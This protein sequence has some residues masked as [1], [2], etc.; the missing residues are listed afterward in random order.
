LPGEPFY[1]WVMATLL[2]MLACLY[3]L[4][5][6]DP[7]RYSGV[8]AVAIVGRMVGALA[9]VVAAVTEPALLPGIA[10]LAACDFVLGAAAALFWLPVER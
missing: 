4:A 2:A 7:R 6:R 3:L 10:V 5:A 8:I 9:F 1:L